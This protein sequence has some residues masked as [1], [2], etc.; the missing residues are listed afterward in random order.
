MRFSACSDNIA[1]SIPK[2]IGDLLVQSEQREVTGE[3]LWSAVTCHRFKSADTSAHSKNNP[4][5]SVIEQFLG[6]FIRDRRFQS[7]RFRIRPL[8]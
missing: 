3:W 2:L 6:L 7:L 1:A 5:P 4:C 8:N